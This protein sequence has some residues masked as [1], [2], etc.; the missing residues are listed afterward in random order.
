MKQK[1]VSLT[2]EDFLWI[3]KQ[4]INLS[5][6]VRTKL[7]EVKNPAEVKEKFVKFQKNKLISLSEG[8]DIFIKS[9]NININ[10]F[11]KNRLEE[12]RNRSDKK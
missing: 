9:N 2:E 3:N 6:Y 4:S 1:M 5:R 7:S 12:D 8:D 10:T 11:V